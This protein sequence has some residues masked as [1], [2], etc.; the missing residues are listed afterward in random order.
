MDVAFLV[1]TAL[2]GTPLWDQVGVTPQ[3]ELVRCR[4]GDELP[5]APHVPP[6]LREL[7]CPTA[8]CRQFWCRVPPLEPPQALG[9]HLGGRLGLRWVQQTPQPRVVLQSSARV[10]YD[11][12]RYWNSGGE[13]RLQIQTELELAEPPSPLPHILGGSV[14]GLLLLALL[15]LGLYKLGFFRRRYKE[16]MEGDETPPAPPADPQG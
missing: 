3:Q 11:V 6:G 14:G 5:G 13:P 4:A 2:G 7:S 1:P 12:G 15:T 10:L 9:F 8:T 16:L